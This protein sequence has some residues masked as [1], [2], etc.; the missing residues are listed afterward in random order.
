MCEMEG[1]TV[2]GVSR[3][4]ELKNKPVQTLG[5]SRFKHC[6][7]FTIPLKNT[8][9]SW[10]YPRLPEHWKNVKSTQRDYVVFDCLDALE[11]QLQK[12]M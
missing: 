1:S 12:R 10:N 7:V 11:I 9:E 5:Y 6:A 8:V 4:K 3:I 2:D